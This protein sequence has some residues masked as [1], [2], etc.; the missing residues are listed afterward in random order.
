MSAFGSRQATRWRQ[1][2]CV[3]WWAMVD[4]QAHARALPRDCTRAQA[5]PMRTRPPSLVH[6]S[7][8]AVAVVAI[9]AGMPASAVA[10]GRTAAP[11]LRMPASAR[12]AALGDAYGAAH[13][14]GRADAASMFY[15][16]AQL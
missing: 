10:Q 14:A 2:V 3:L 4:V 1:A 15:N 7:V 6:R 11:L 9:V 12:A 5:S 8:T 13:E 16:P